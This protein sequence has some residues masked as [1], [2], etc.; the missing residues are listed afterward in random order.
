[1]YRISSLYPHRSIVMSEAA[2]IVGAADVF[3]DDRN[4]V[5]PL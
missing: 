1:M 5:N 2:R 4:H 3:L